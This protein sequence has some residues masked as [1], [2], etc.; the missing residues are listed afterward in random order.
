LSRG[1]VAFCA[2]MTSDRPRYVMALVT[3]R[4]PQ[5]L[6]EHLDDRVY[7]L[8]PPTADEDPAKASLAAAREI[9]DAVAPYATAAF[10]SFCSRPESFHRAIQEAE[11]V[12]DVLRHGA[13]TK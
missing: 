11:L 7:A 3:E 9:A 8:L 10:S 5:A 4:Q 6:I 13:D 2:E 12:L 1:A